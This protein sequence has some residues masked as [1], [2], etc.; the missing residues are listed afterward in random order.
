[1]GETPTKWK[2][3]WPPWVDA[4]LKIEKPI[5]E[6]LRDIAV[7]YPDQIAVDFYGTR[8]SYRAL[9]EKIDRFAWGL[10]TLGLQSGDRVAIQ[11]PN[12]PQFIIGYFGILRAGGLVVAMNP[13]FKA[14]ELEFEIEDAAAKIV[15]CSDGLYQNVAK[16]RNKLGLKHL[17]V[18]NL[19]DE[20]PEN[21]CLPLPDELKPAGVIEGLSEGHT[22]SFQHLVDASP[23]KAICRVDDLKSDLALLQYTGGTTGMPKGAMISHYGLALAALG[24]TNWFD[25]TSAD[26]CLG[27]TPFFHIMGMVQ[28]MC[29]PLTSGAKLVVLSRFVTDTVA[30]ALGQHKC[31]AWVGATT[32]LIALLQ[33]EKIK[34]YDFSSLR[35][36]VS[37]GAPIGVEIQRRFNQLIPQATMIEGYGLTEC[38]SQGAAITPI[39]GHRSGYVGVPHLNAIKIVDLVHGVGEMP[40]GEM[41]EI[42]LKGSCLMEGYWRQPEET[43]KVLREGWLYTGDI[44]AMDEK[45]YLKISGR[46]KE[47]IKCSGFSVF[48]DEVENLMYRHEAVA[49]VAVI[50]VPD[51]YRG[52][53][54]KA[55]V[56]LTPSYKDRITAKE[57]LDWCKANMAAYKCPRYIEFTEDL[58]KSAAGKVLRRMLKPPA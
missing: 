30:A 55:F 26:T 8:I 53:S 19:S 3:F 22:I 49:E 11:M 38:I 15:I 17:I 54:P 4:D 31:T 7:R 27:V 37:G 14:A 39:G 28:V 56:V 9:N 45:G 43:Q 51:S 12:C 25:L 35:F 16:L 48:P 24:A 5:S 50:G 58:P 57:V 10:V 46:N 41:G 52:E 36:V 13:M 47:L 33:M 23:T 6:Y 34:N 40:A 2:A 20:A 1:M 32:M 21:P 29:S 18:A 42:V 44:G